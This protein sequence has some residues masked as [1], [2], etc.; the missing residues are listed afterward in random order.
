[1]VITGVRGGSSASQKGLSPGDVIVEV[2]QEE[3]KTPQDVARKVEEASNEGY[4]VVTLLV[5]SQGDFRWV[6]VKIGQG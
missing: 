6:A 4:R 3:V 1:V 2:D 5:Y